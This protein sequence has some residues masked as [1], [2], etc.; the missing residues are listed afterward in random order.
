VV[1]E[2]MVLVE[3]TAILLTKGVKMVAKVVVVKV[4]VKKIRASI[5]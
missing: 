1:A 3:E 2:A 4:R 5:S